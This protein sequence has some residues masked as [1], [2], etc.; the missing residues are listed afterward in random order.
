VDGALAWIGKIADWIGSFIPRWEIIN[1]T[2]GG[3]KFVRGREV[4]ALG[5]G[6]HLWWPLTT[7]LRTYPTARQTVNLRAQTLVTADDHT[8]A[9]AGMV[10]YRIRDIEAILARTYDPDNTIEE[11][12]LAVVNQ[13]CCRMTWDD[14][15]TAH[16]TGSLDTLLRL[17]VR[18]EL[19]RYGV[20]VLK[21]TLTDLAPCRVIKLLQ[22]K[23]D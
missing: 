2:H 4:V 21:T 11:I 23:G 18:R 10:V 6:W 1:T 14:L 16:E 12:A 7:N 19:R 3:V 5:P 9:V 17:G 8:I 22:A 13:V 15:K 20:A